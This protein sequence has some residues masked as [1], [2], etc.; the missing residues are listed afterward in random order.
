M[1]SSYFPKE[2]YFFTVH[3]SQ[4]LKLM[5][6]AQFAPQDPRFRSPSRPIEITN[7]KMVRT[8]TLQ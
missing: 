7:F 2:L 1:I 3:L 5:L 6:I 4:K 8:S